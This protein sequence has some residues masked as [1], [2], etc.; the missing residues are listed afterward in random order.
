MSDIS[1]P[2]SEMLSEMSNPAPEP[3]VKRHWASKKCFGGHEW[4]DPETGV[5]GA[6]CL[7]CGRK[8]PKRFYAE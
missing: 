4:I 6:V 8:H 7:R 3:K 5:R 1:L 2:D